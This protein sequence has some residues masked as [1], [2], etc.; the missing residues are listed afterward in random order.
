ML[1]FNF[2]IKDAQNRVI[3]GQ[4][5]EFVLKVKSAYLFSV[6]GYNGDENIGYVCLES[7]SGELYHSGNFNFLK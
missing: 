3:P 7:K 6:T 1:I 4:L 2:K 5:G